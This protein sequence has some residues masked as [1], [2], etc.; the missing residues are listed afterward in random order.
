[1]ES[2]FSPTHTLRRCDP[3]P[4]PVATSNLSFAC[5]GDAA[6]HG[7][8]ST[9][10]F[11]EMFCAVQRDREEVLM[12]LAKDALAVGL[13]IVSTGEKNDR[14][15]CKVVGCEFTQEWLDSVATPSTEF[16][17]E[18]IRKALGECDIA[19]RCHVA[20]EAA[21]IRC[22]YERAGRSSN[23]AFSLLSEKRILT[24][25][26]QPENRAFVQPACKTVNSAYERLCFSLTP[27]SEIPKEVR[28]RILLFAVLRHVYRTKADARWT[29]LRAAVDEHVRA[30]KCRGFTW[31]SA[32]AVG[33]D[34]FIN[35]LECVNF[36]TAAKCMRVCAEFRDAR[37]LRCLLPHLSVRRVVGGFP[38]VVANHAGSGNCDYVVRKT[39]CYVFVDLVRTVHSNCE[40]CRGPLHPPNQV[41]CGAARTDAES[42]RWQTTTT[43]PEESCDCDTVAER[44]RFARQLRIRN[45]AEEKVDS[46]RFRRRL[47]H[48]LFFSTPIAC[49]FELV[50]ADTHAPVQSDSRSILTFP[51]FMRKS[52]APTSTLTSNNNVPYPAHAA[53]WVDDLSQNHANRPFKI[54]VTGEAKTRFKHGD[55]DS[56]RVATLVAYSS[57]FEVISAKRVAA[58]T[59]RA[60]KTKVR[61]N[62]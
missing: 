47:Q 25:L 33:L 44:R 32:S 60:L 46:A 14:M 28:S 1:M 21:Q 13:D 19:F 58:A 2:P 8:N 26:G 24:H 12:Q 22:L 61:K 54:K 41:I 35:I 56:V 38:H 31:L 16:Y 20:D 51:R 30:R 18:R 36:R 59:G 29:H 4:A 7:K 9:M 34:V 23:A 45:A 55:A 40:P 52:G 11:V 39:L 3:P 42:V 6:R 37:E 27:R 5:E 53:F 15:V 48:C 57:P 10:S 62:H 43:H 49:K 17:S 50:Y